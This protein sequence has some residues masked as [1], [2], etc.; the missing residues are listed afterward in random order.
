MGLDP[1]TRCFALRRV[2]PFLG[3]VAV[4]KTPTARALSVDGLRW[5]IQILA[6]PPRGLWPGGGEQEG[7][8]YFRFGLWSEA[9][10]MTRVPL[11][12]ILDAGLMVAESQ[13]LIAEVQS[14]APS[15]PFPLGPELELW[16]LDEEAL[17][18]ALLATALPQTDLDEAASGDWTAGG[19]GDERPFVS[20]TLAAQGLVERDASGR[21]YHV[22]TLERLVSQRAG[23]RR[24]SQ[25]F[26]IQGDEALG[27]N[28]RVEP[29]LW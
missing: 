21:R 17:P 26:R 19:R 25:W 14:A 8:R 22:E 13:R 9:E 3:V 2:N 24:R 4:V 28:H 1:E 11:N 27:L 15:L 12:P 7:L 20:P 10:G 16:L 18:L 6:H 29:D 5:Q 23:T